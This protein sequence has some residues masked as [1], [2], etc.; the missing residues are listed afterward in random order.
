MANV[1]VEKVLSLHKRPIWL[2][3]WP[4]SGNTMF[5]IAAKHYYGIGS[6]SVYPEGTQCSERPDL[7]RQAYD[8]YPEPNDEIVLVKT[9][10][11]ETQR[12]PTILLTR[13]GREATLSYAFFLRDHVQ[14]N[15]AQTLDQGLK[16]ALTYGEG[17]MPRTWALFHEEWLQVPHVR[18]DYKTLVQYPAELVGQAISAALGENVERITDEPMPT[19]EELHAKRPSFFRR[20]K[21]SFQR[22]A[23]PEPKL[24]LFWSTHHYM[25]KRLGYTR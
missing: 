3:S 16:M 25:M 11:F 14:A 12:I 6:I 4:R 7:V 24:R 17:R 10:D 5:R 19:F 21:A 8:F 22:E 18:A 20:G 23:Y 9:H 15:N 13:D 1:D 2:A